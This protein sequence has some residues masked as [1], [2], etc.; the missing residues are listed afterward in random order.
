MTLNPTNPMRAA[1]ASVLLFEIIIVWLAYI[2]MIQV[3]GTNLALAAGAC[4]A[5]TLGCIA[6]LAGLRRRWGYIVGWVVQI[7]CIALGL[8]TAWMFAMGIIFAMIWVTCMVLG[9]RLEAAQTG[10]DNT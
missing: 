2:G 7:G 3:S 4:A 5:V 8:L 9:K 1:A 10:R 6:A